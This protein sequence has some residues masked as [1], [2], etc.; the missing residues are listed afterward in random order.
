[1]YPNHSFHHQGIP[2]EARQTGNHQKHTPLCKKGAKKTKIVYEANLNF[3]TA[4]AY[5]DWL[6]NQKMIIKEDGSFKTTLRG[7]ELLSDLQSV[8]TFLDLK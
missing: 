1:M 2:Y 3:K 5:L 8:S 6:I 4:G 7:A